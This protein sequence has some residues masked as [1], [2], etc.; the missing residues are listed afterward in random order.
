M[1][2]RC[3]AGKLAKIANEV[4]LVGV[5]AGVR[6]SDPARGTC[7][8]REDAYRTLEAGDAR[9]LLGRQANVAQEQPFELAT[10]HAN[11]CG[12]VFDCDAAS[13]PDDRVDDRCHAAVAG[14][15]PLDTGKQVLD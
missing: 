1:I 14:V 12:D 9:E 6:G 8:L 15:G 3:A 4:S 2:G 11:L 10:A 7:V 13:A 5:A